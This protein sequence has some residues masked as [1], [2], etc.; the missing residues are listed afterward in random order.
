[1]KYTSLLL[2]ILT[3]TS[4]LNKSETKIIGTYKVA[5]CKIREGY[6]YVNTT[7]YTLLLSDDKTFVFNTGRKKVNGNW[8]AEDFRD[9]T[10][11]EF[12]FDSY[13]FDT[14]GS[15]NQKKELN[16]LNAHHFLDENIEDI[17]FNKIK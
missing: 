1:M 2:L 11:I 4:C 15:I 17:T 7:P 14:Q 13:D 16:V 5:S 12:Y 8:K 10:H 3:L 9:E 6:K